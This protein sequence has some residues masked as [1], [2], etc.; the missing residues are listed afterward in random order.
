MSTPPVNAPALVLGDDPRIRDTGWVSLNLYGL[1]SNVFTLGPTWE[2]ASTGGSGIRVRRIGNLVTLRVVGTLRCTAPANT[3]SELFVEDFPSGYRLAY[4]MV[5]LAHRT[6]G[7][8][9]AQIGAGLSS[10]NRLRVLT[11]ASPFT[12]GYSQ[13]SWITDNAFPA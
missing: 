11:T 9:L 3:E 4:E 2:W 6:A 10:G 7:G 5:P 12:F 1:P 8:G 13:V